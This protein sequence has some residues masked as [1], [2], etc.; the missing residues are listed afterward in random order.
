MES[1]AKVSKALRDLEWERDFF[2]SRAGGTFLGAGMAS[3]LNKHNAVGKSA[4]KKDGD[5]LVG[6]P[7]VDDSE[8]GSSCMPRA[9]NSASS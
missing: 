4:S 5:D 3:P 8:S 9:N 2:C 7:G 6:T 1:S